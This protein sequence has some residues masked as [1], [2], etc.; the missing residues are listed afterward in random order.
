MIVVAPGRRAT[1]YMITIRIT[2]DACLL[3]CH[4]TGLHYAC[5][6]CCVFYS[7]CIK[8][9]VSL[10]IQA[11]KADSVS[12]ST[13]F[14]TFISLFVI[15]YHCFRLHIV[16]LPFLPHFLHPS[17]KMSS[18]SLVFQGTTSQKIYG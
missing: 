17:P 11:Y 14:H 7:G 10:L 3:T 15:I 1:Y 8:P 9:V 5:F 6:R 13:S 4:T 12:A 18:K 16:N 2:C